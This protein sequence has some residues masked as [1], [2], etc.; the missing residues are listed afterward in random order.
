MYGFNLAHL[1]SRSD[2]C[3]IMKT[4]RTYLAYFSPTKTSYKVGQAIATGCD[5]SNSIIELNATF[6]PVQ[7]QS[8]L[9]SND[10]LIVSVPV[11]GGHIAPLAIERLKNLQGDSTPAVAIVTY[12]NRNFENAAIELQNF[13]SERGF[14]VV[15]AGAFIGE[16]SYCTKEYPISPLRP[17][18]ADLEEAK[19]FGIQIIEKINKNTE[20]VLINAETL[21]CPDSG[22]DNLLGFKSFIKNY[23]SGNQAQSAPAKIIPIVDEALCISCGYCAQ[24]CPTEAIDESNPTKT[25]PEKCIKCCACVKFCPENARILNT[26]FAPVLSKY[27]SREKE[28]V[29]TL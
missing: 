9:T 5:S 3:F 21:K 14:N 28:N 6:H 23:Q 15:A 10:L 1:K 24:V 26:P 8:N 18:I 13:L 7:P 22:E 20:P 2:I 12:G 11:Y 25:D 16:H 27:F 19:K 4:D 17:N 29:Y